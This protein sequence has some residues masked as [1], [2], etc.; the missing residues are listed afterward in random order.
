VEATGQGVLM[1]GRAHGPVLPF[2]ERGVRVA[3]L[4]AQRG[5]NRPVEAL[6]RGQVRDGDPDV[7]E[8][9]AKATGRSDA[10]LMLPAGGSKPACNVASERHGPGGPAGLQNL[11][12]R[13]AHGSVG[14]T[15]APLRQT[16]CAVRTGLVARSALDVG[17]TAWPLE[18]VRGCLG[19][20]GTVAGMLQT[21]VSAWPAMEFLNRVRK[22]DSC[23]GHT[24]HP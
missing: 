15:P 16:D 22:F 23:R 17:A 3:R 5:K 2:D 4:D 10:R 7:V 18:T 11:C 12:G 9:A 14:S 24:A 19:R 6:G 20:G 13:V 1:S 21:S 8:H